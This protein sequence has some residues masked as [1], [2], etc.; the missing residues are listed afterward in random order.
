VPEV[1]LIGQEFSGHAPGPKMLVFVSD[2][3]LLM[4][5]KATG[6]HWEPMLEMDLLIAGFRH[7]IKHRKALHL[8]VSVLIPFIKT[9]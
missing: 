7:R 4:Q 2:L 8:L 3:I 6:P 1:C 9:T 5:G